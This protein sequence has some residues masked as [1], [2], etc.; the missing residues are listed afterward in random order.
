MI[1]LVCSAKQGWT[2]TSACVI[3]GVCVR[4]CVCVC[5]CVYV[6]VCVCDSARKAPQKDA[7]DL[8]VLFTKQHVQAAEL[9]PDA[10]ILAR[11]L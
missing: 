9:R 7:A 1:G 2:R 10:A 6:C 5:V 8:A 3:L 4:V 11:S